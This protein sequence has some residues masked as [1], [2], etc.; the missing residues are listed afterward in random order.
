MITLGNFSE[1]GLKSWRNQEFGEEMQVD[2]ELVLILIAI[3]QSQRDPKLQRIASNMICDRDQDMS[4]ARI[5]RL[6]ASNK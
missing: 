4:A 1:N 3:K 6:I 5:P 2:R